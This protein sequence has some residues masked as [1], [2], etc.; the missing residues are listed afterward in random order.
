MKDHPDTVK[1]QKFITDMP[2]AWLN[3]ENSG[4]GHILL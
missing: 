3:A 1:K 4:T 2:D